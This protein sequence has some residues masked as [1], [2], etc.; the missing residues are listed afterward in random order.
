[1]LG[2]WVAGASRYKTLET[3]HQQRAALRVVAFYKALEDST[4]AASVKVAEAM[5]P[6]I[7]VVALGDQ[8]TKPLPVMKAMIEE[9]I[10]AKSV[11]TYDAPLEVCFPTLIDHLPRSNISKSTTRT[12]YTQIEE[13][14]MRPPSCWVAV[15]ENDRTIALAVE[16]PMTIINEP[17]PI[18]IRYLLV[19]AGLVGIMAFG[20][21]KIAAAPLRRLRKAAFEL[22]DDINHS[23]LDERGPVEVQD[24]VKAFNIMQQK[25]KRHIQDRTRM[26]AAI[27][28]DLQTPMTRLRLRLEQI[29]NPVLKAQFLSDWEAMRK[30]VEEGL[31]LARAASDGETKIRLD[32]DSLIASVISDA[33]DAGIEANFSGPLGLQVML[34]PDS[35]RRC[36]GNLINNAWT[37]AGGAE[38]YVER[39]ANALAI[40]V[41]DNGPGVPE[42]QLEHIME[43]FVR[44]KDSITKTPSGTGLGL[45]IA[46]ELVER[47]G[48]QLTLKNREEGGLEAVILLPLSSILMPKT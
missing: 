45:S 14:Q 17:P 3:L 15:I 6:G 18:D 23:A 21:A 42:S 29:E 8:L 28:H 41:I 47:S 7:H 32:L 4:S 44:L 22:S 38:V 43:P 31:G 48:G 2:Q 40:C 16:T 36:L 27:S 34:A 13:W 12:V 1:M 33:E 9:G 5:I 11:R 26:L 19:L 10:I 35:M 20:I 39:R 25:L 37:H 24:A 30:L 46:R